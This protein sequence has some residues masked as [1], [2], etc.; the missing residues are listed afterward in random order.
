MFRLDQSNETASFE[1]CGEIVVNRNEVFDGEGYRF[2]CLQ[3][4][5]EEFSQ[6]PDTVKQLEVYI[7]SPGGS[8]SA[9]ME[10][11][12]RLHDFPAPVTVTIGSNAK[13]AASVI[14]CAG[15]TVR[16]HPS[17]VVMIHKGWR[18]VIENMNADDMREC[19]KDLDISD[20][21]MAK[22]YSL[23]SKKTTEEILQAM[24]E[25]TY[26]VG[27]EAVDYGL[28]DFVIEDDGEVNALSIEEVKAVDKEM[29]RKQMLDAVKAWEEANAKDDPEKEDPEKKED[30]QQ[31]PDPSEQEEEKPE[32][33][34]AKCKTDDKKCEVDYQAEYER[35]ASLFAFGKEANLTFDMVNSAF[36]SGANAD[37]LARE[38]VIAT[39]SRAQAQ[40]KEADVKKKQIKDAYLQDLN[41]TEGVPSNPV[42]DVNAKEADKDSEWD[43]LIQTAKK[44]M[45]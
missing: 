6:L 2:F 38:I 32:E 35:I 41:E 25:T 19:I 17:S 43:F 39:A 8:Q 21:Q 31:K 34:Q 20:A 11:Y 26:L 9:G 30:D 7:D 1:I 36:E 45:Y 16:V 33:D 18:P 14:M 42:M 15:D 27:R 5:E 40:A 12:Q 23:K 13:S 28:A 22:V 37:Q 10:V 29:L 24:S 44:E 3:E 4:F